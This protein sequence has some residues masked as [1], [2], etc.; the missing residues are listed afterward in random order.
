MNVTTITSHQTPLGDLWSSWS[1]LGLYRLSWEK[2]KSASQANSVQVVQLDQ[3]LQEYFQ[4]GRANFD[5]VE[6][7]P[8]GW[9]EFSRRIYDGCRQI[10]SGD[11]VTYKELARIAGRERASRAVGTAMAKNRVTIVIPCH[12]VVASGGKIGGYGGP[13]GLEL[14]RKLLELERIK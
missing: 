3:L 6:I 1:P 13:G 10:E 14:K 2:H 8:T 11:T 12:R 4:T 5:R 7:D 9:T